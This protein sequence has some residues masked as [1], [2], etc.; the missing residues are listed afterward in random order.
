MLLNADRAERQ[1]KTHKV[2][3]PEVAA[4]PLLKKIVK[5]I[6]VDYGIVKYYMGQGMLLCHKR[7]RQPIIDASDACNL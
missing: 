1:I 2:H 4:T 5:K 6:P 7:S 3:K